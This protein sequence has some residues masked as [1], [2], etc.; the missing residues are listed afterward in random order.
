MSCKSLSMHPNSTVPLTRA[1][2]NLAFLLTI[3]PADQA[4][5]WAA[6]LADQRATLKKQ[7][8]VAGV[9]LIVSAFGEREHPTSQD[10]TGVANN[11][12]EFVLNNNLDS[13]DI[14][15]ERFNLVIQQ[16]GVGEAWLTT[17]TQTLRQQ[18]PQ[19]HF[20]LTH[21]RMLFA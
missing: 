21:A 6:L 4:A 1:Y 17:L 3:G 18:L 5:N 8:N 15:Y 2:S 14:D 20:I 11:L 16:P 13:I 12:A 7:Y 10:P 9:S 19:G